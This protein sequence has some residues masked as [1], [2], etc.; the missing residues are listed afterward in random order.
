MLS[1]RLRGRA[2]PLR[3]GAAGS[4]RAGSRSVLMN[5]SSER[6]DPLA[7]PQQAGAGEGRGAPARVPDQTVQKLGVLGA[8]MMGARHRLRRGARPGI[9]VVLID[10]DQEAAD[11]GKAHV[12]G[13]L[14]EGVKR[15]K[16][17]PEQR[18][19]VLGAHHRHPGLRR[20]RRLRP[21]GRGGLRGPGASRPRRPAGPR[22]HLGPDAIFA[23]NTSTL[24]I[25]ELARASRDPARFI[26]IHFFSPVEKMMLVEIIRGPRDRRPGGG[27]G[28]RLRAPDPQDADRRQRRPL[29][30]RQPLHHPLHQRGGAHGGRGRGA[31]ADRERR[32]AAR[33]AARAAAARRRDLDRPRGE[34]RQGD[35]GGDGRRLSREPGRRRALP[36]SPSSAGSGARRRAGFYAYDDKGKRAGPLAG[37]RASSGRRAP[38]QP[39]AR[40][41]CSTGWR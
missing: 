16:T 13:I 11:R 6:D 39:D 10:R 41:R 8:G 40:P 27:Q 12:A 2:R 17:T 15:K 20:A 3:H 26:G 1:A 36:R 21:G 37:A 24:P 25:S 4:R 19:E 5:P 7:L 34:D 33:H 14:D 35:Q 30:L 29:L 31:G 22:R 38:T 9:E 23:T 18:D 32:A 28:A